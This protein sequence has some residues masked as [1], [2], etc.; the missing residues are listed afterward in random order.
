MYLQFWFIGDSRTFRITDVKELFRLKRD[1]EKYQEDSTSITV[2][3]YTC[4]VEGGE[5][6]QRK[7]V[8]FHEIDRMEVTV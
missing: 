5:R 4:E 8:I 7:S 1:Y 3:Y 2:D 6:F